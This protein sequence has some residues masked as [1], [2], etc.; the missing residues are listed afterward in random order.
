MAGPKKGDMP[1]WLNP[2]VQTGVAARDGDIWICSPIKSG[3]NWMMNIVYQ[4]LSRGDPDFDS[5]YR[6]VPW[7]ELVERPG[8]PAAEIH[9]RIAAMPAGVRRAFKTHSPPAALPYVKAGQGKDVRYV[10][11]FRNPEEALVSAKV[12]F[13]MHTQAFYDLWQVP[14]AALTRPDFPAFYRE[15][16]DAKGMQG[17]VFGLLAG[18]W[19]LR[20]EPNVL[21][22][23]FADIK[24]DPSAALRKVA[25][26]LD[27]SPSAS[28]W[29]AIEQYC[30]FKWM[31][32]HESKF[33]TFPNTPVPVLSSGAMIRK[34]KTGAAHEDG[35]T[36]ELAAHL[37]GVGAQICPDQAAL[38]WCY[39]GGKL[40]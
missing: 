14:K 36:H 16:I 4:L 18:W 22:M 15:V 10:V 3:T 26:F 28:Q 23:H 29:S 2:E 21:F 8:Q 30:S 17:A 34:G 40:P 7:P 6:V 37:R 11:V 25:S 12:F 1:P 9:G 31:K 35:M 33:E 20:H 24:Q 32:D 39:S 38:R 5:I 27:I 19:P 13:E